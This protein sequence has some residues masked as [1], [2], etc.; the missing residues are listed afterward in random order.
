M[1]AW[2]TFRSPGGRALLTSFLATCGVVFLNLEVLK[3]FML[4]SQIDFRA[5]RVSRSSWLAVGRGL[6]LQLTVQVSPATRLARFTLRLRP[7]EQL[8]LGRASVSTVTCSL[9]RYPVSQNIRIPFLQSPCHTDLRHKSRL[10][11][12]DEIKKVSKILSSCFI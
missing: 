4:L 3:R 9:S 1:L 2:I 5:F 6:L 8:A 10:I 11:H 12:T 7:T